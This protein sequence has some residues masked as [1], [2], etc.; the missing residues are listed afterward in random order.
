LDRDRRP[1][2][3][4]EVQD[5]HL[6]RDMD[7]E[8]HLLFGVD[9]GKVAFAPAKVVAVGSVTVA[10]TVE[11]NLLLLVAMSRQRPCRQTPAVSSAEECR[12]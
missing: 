6:L 1:Q 3:L 9:P 2:G 10:R 8:E 4:E 5:L 11:P 12:P 7:L